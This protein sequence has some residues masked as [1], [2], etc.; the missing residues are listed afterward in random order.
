MDTPF[1]TPRFS[2][3]A[4][5][6]A[7]GGLGFTVLTGCGNI[8]PSQEAAQVPAGGVHSDIKDV[9]IGF[10]QQQLQAPY[11]SAMQVEAEKIAAEEGFHLLFQSANKDPVIQMNQMQAMLSQ[12]ANVLVV[13]A[14]SVRVRNR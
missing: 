12:G 7:A 9:V 10:A 4:F 6:L 3:R 1:V 14:T 8:Y 5:T 13:N 11:F 2:R